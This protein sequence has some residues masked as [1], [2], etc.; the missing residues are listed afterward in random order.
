MSSTYKTEIGIDEI[1]SHAEELLGM[2]EPNINR[3]SDYRITSESNYPTPPPIFAING[4]SIATAGNIL[5]ISGL[6][7]SGKSSI[8][9]I[10]ISG[11][12]H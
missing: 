1:N 8:T 2:L 10:L 7:K 4:Q 12:L 5:V 6:Q 11:F 3:W 9:N